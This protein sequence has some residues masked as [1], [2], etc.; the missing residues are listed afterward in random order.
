[1]LKN[2]MYSI[3]AL[4]IGVFIYNTYI[5]ED[6]LI[7]VNIDNDM[8]LIEV[9]YKKDGYRVEADEQIEKEAEKK[10][11]FEM[12]RAFFQKTSLKGN[13]GNFDKL[14]SNLLLSGDVYGINKENN[15][16]IQGDEIQYIQNLDLFYTDKGMSAYNKENDLRISGDY[17]E[18]DTEITNLKLERNVHAFSDSYDIKAN[19]AYY[20]NKN[21]I[22]N[23]EGN[24]KVVAKQSEENEKQKSELE[25][26]FLIAVYDTVNRVLQS[27][28]SFE[29]RYDGYTIKGDYL[30]YDQN[31]GI[32]IAE[33][34]VV[35][36]K[37]DTQLFTPKAVLDQNTNI[38]SLHGKVRGHRLEQ[39]LEGNMAYINTETEDIELIGEVLVFDKE[40]RIEGDKTYF[41]KSKEVLKIF[42]EGKEIVYTNEDMKFFFNYGE[43]HLLED[44]FYIPEEFRAIAKDGDGISVFLNGET[45][46]YNTINK[47]G[48]AKN[49]VLKK[50]S[51]F[52]EAEN[53]AFDFQEAY[54]YL[55]GEVRGF[56]ADYDIKSMNV[57]YDSLKEILY[58]K[59]PY[60]IYSQASNNKI[61]GKDAVIRQKENLISSKERTYFEK[62]DIFAYGDA[63]LYNYE[64]QEGTFDKNIFLRSEEKQLTIYGN[65]AK[66]KLETYFEL[67]ENVKF[68][69]GEYRAETEKVIYEPNKE[70]ATFPTKTIMWSSLKDFE[71]NVSKGKYKLDTEIF[72][73]ENYWGRSK[74]VE[75]KGDFVEYSLPKEEVILKNNVRIQDKETNLDLET[76]R[77]IYYQATN[78]AILPEALK[79]IR[80]NILID[81]EKG[82]IDLLNKTIQLERPI[83][84]TS[85]GDHIEGDS[86]YG[87]YLKNEFNFDNNIKGKI[88]TMNEE[89]LNSLEEVD[90]E[91]PLKFQGNI[92][93][94][95]FVED[96]NGELVVTRSEIRD[97]SKFIYKDMEL[98]GDFLEAE[99]LSQNLFAKGNSIITIREDNRISAESI[100]LHL[101]SESAFMTNNVRISNTSEA[102][103]G[104][105]TRSDKADFSNIS[106]K[107]N[108]E[109]NI[110][111]YKGQTKLLADSGVFDLETGILQG[112]GN[113][114]LSMDIETYEETK[115]KKKQDEENRKKIALAKENISIPRKVEA[116]TN[117]IDLLSKY[118]DVIINWETSNKNIIDIDGTIKHPMYNG[119][120]S[121]IK[122]SATYSI[123]ETK[124]IV[125]YYIRVA[126]ED[127][128]NYL[129]SLANNLVFNYSSDEDKLFI[130]RSNKYT[131]KFVDE[132]K[133]FDDLGEELIIISK[134]KEKLDKSFKLIA[135]LEDV[136]YEVIYGLL[137]IDNKIILS[138][139]ENELEDEVG[140]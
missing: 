92:A 39:N 74:L 42:G 88:F 13:E 90:Y 100:V 112:K 47:N 124:E 118:E 62:D 140:N 121:I 41:D 103:G 73:G 120:E 30:E 85:I 31:T 36:T 133:I 122:I 22:L 1:M 40:N 132:Y 32:L 86:L 59:N 81:A 19:R 21:G 110:E 23:L 12:A 77:L 61:Y 18:S 5:K 115:M 106:N 105:N 33:K 25:G 99:G 134:S 44:N 128:L 54:H 126:R 17:F 7:K 116:N 95:Y 43:Y 117:Y 46:V 6:E 108:L 67:Y 57:E 34:N 24:I 8:R 109:G 15:W 114:N 130:E 20:N 2:I 89:Q 78:Y 51:N 75:A 65:R 16:E 29:I 138:R 79:I 102:L 98:K 35:L 52:L 113:I 49:P 4:L 70:L 107:V 53:I 131:S 50:E 83:L 26:D 48:T 82:N 68:E 125:E 58:L 119:E 111:S 80:N 97:N 101:P 66:F 104:V 139:L 11:Y 123:G 55:N 28:A 63:L 9:T 10:V 136:S 72:Y 76:E 96:I 91:N 37:E 137:L 71:T 129:K 14:S 93:S 27:N 87:D 45:L 38:L 84:T 56:Y 135:Y 60:E 94:L 127:K 3:L 69:H 64:S